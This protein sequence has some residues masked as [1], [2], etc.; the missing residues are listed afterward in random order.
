[1]DKYP[2][3]LG[4]LGH[5]ISQLKL[6]AIMEGYAKVAQLMSTYEEFAILR[7]FK[8]LNYQNLLYLQAQITH[9]EQDIGQL[10]SQDAADPHRKQYAVDWLK[11]A[12]GGG[13]AGKAQWRKFCAARKKLREYNEALLQQAYIS[14]FDGPNPTD[15]EFLRSC[16]EYR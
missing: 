13:R 7:R 9:L 2:G 16:L 14:K 5:H 3:K 15:L 12:N 4:V 8:R 1:M 10:A 6:L 11:L